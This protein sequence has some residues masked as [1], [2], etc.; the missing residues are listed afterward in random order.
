MGIQ[1]GFC[2]I[3]DSNEGEVKRPE[4]VKETLDK[5]KHKKIP[6]VTPYIKRFSEH[7]RRVLGNTA[8]QHTSS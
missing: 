5:E 6:V 8:F 3:D 1:I 4:I 2:T 7:I